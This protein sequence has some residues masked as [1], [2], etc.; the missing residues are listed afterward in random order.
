[1]VFH[2]ASSVQLLGNERERLTV[3]GAS[4]TRIYPAWRKP[5]AR[6]GLLLLGDQTHGASQANRVL[7]RHRLNDPDPALPSRLSL[8]KPTNGP[9]ALRGSFCLPEAEAFSSHE[10]AP[11]ERAH[12]HAS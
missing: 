10:V 9:A 3:R 4:V 11:T 7:T 6:C 2:G 1:M 5:D 8:A 12:R